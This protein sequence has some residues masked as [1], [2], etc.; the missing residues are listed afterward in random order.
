MQAALLAACVFLVSF[1]VYS[2]TMKIV[3]VRSSEMSVDFYRN[4]WRYFPKYVQ[5]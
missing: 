1:L 5:L 2:Q 3:P 4:T